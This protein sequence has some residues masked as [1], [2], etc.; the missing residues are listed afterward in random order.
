MILVWQ[1][2]G[3]L[4]FLVPVVVIVLCNTLIPMAAGND[5][6]TAA[7]VK[8]WSA[9]AGCFLAGVGLW[10]LGAWMNRK[11]RT[12][13]ADPISGDPVVVEDGGGHT[14]FWIPVQYW[15]IAW[16]AFGLFLMFS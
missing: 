14:L 5:P 12:V 13:E 1:R 16:V 15:S 4:A 10:P 11:T 3:C 9:V 8:K 2:L 6:E 7:G